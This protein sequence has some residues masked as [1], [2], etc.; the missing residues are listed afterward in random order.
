[1]YNDV[2]QNPPPELTAETFGDLFEHC[3]P[4]PQTERWT[5]VQWETDL[6][7][8]RQRAAQEGKPLFIWAMNGHPV[9]CV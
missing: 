9:G 2:I 5:E 3:R 4:K 8:A 1:M 6:W 7:P